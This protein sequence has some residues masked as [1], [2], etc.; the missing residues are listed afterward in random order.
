MLIFQMKESSLSEISTVFRKYKIELIATNKLTT[1]Q[2]WVLITWLIVY[3]IEQ[4]DSD[5]KYREY[6][7]KAMTWQ[8]W[9]ECIAANTRPTPVKFNSRINMTHIKHNRT[10]ETSFPLTLALTSTSPN[11][12]TH[13]LRHYIRHSLTQQFSLPPSLNHCSLPTHSLPRPQ[14]FAQNTTILT[15]DYI[16]RTSHLKPSHN[17]SNISSVTFLS[18][19]IITNTTRA[20]FTAKS[21]PHPS[22]CRNIPSHSPCLSHNSSPPISKLQE[23]SHALLTITEEINFQAKRPMMGPRMLKE[24]RHCAQSLHEHRTKLMLKQHRPVKN[25]QITHLNLAQ[26]EGELPSTLPKWNTT[27]LQA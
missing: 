1:I 2:L 11:H 14:S 19:S 7:H 23:F 5:R 21:S 22:Y 15:H 27:Q 12:L 25:C 8:K 24:Q 6:K 17:Q 13:R 20:S 9:K 4:C 18:S 26:I 16:A 3:F 10:S